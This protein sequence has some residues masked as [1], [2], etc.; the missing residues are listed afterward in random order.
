[1]QQQL[2]WREK[3]E[4]GTLWRPGFL[5]FGFLTLGKLHL[6]HGSVLVF[7]SRGLDKM[8]LSPRTVLLE[9][10]SSSTQPSGM[11]GFLTEVRTCCWHGGWSRGVST[12]RR[13]PHKCWGGAAWPLRALQLLLGECYQGRKQREGVRMGFRR[14]TK[15]RNDLPPPRFCVTSKKN[16]C[17]RYP[18]ACLP[19]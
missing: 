17:Y 4:E 11:A 1:M 9:W 3:P 6:L 19:S 5:A 16:G 15:A 12:A 13:N 8:L 7:V 18:T 10:K 14:H 2:F